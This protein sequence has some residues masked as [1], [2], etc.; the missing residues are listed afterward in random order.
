MD[1]LLIAIAIAAVAIVVAVVAERRRRPQAPSGVTHRAP[2][3]LDRAD[4]VHPEQPWLVVLFSAERCRTCAAVR[5]QIRALADPAVAVQEVEESADPELHR[6]YR[7][8][9]LPTVVV[10]DHEGVTR[11]S[12]LGPVPRGEIAAE[13]ASLGGR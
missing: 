2:A 8:T 7:V 9:G 11:A 10:V 13:L 12:W 5:D 3:Q 1:R 4:F 6:R